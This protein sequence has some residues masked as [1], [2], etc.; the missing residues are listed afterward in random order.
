MASDLEKLSR[1]LHRHGYT[2]AGDLVGALTESLRRNNLLPEF[3]SGEPVVAALPD[4][5]G[6]VV[7]SVRRVRRETQADVARRA[8]MHPYSLRR[9]EAGRTN[10]RA[11]TIQALADALEVPVS[12]LLNGRTAAHVPRND[13]T[14]H[15]DNSV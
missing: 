8:G 13:P 3:L 1:D 6:S 12:A 7:R 5:I 11:G 4:H 14:R 15:S 2:V 9:I 10:P